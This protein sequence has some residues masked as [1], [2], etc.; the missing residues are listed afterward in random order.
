MKN[1]LV[2]VISTMFVLMGDSISANAS[3]IQNLTVI[4]NK[5]TGS[6]S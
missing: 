5:K 6:S 4:S 3:T 2:Y 1:F